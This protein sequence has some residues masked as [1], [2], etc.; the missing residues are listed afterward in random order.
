VVNFFG[1]VNVDDGAS[2]GHDLVNLFGGVR[3]G[4]DASVGKNA[5]VIFGRLHQAD[6]A[7]VGGDR[8]VRPGWIFWLPLLVVCLGVGFARQ[9]ARMARRRM[10]LGGY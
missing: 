6:S 5:V 1:E 2:V 8:V 3:L 10:I 4:E 9:E 7:S